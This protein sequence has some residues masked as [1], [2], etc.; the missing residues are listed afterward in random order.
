MIALILCNALLSSVFAQGC[1]NDVLVDDFSTTQFKFFDN[2]NRTI[3]KLGGD[4]GTDGESTFTI[5]TTAQ[6]LTFIPQENENIFFFAKFVSSVVI[7]DRMKLL[8]LT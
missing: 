4:Y 7:N 6:T 3:N 5:D 8:A 2:A 1:G